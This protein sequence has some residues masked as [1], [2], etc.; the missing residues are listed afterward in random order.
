M[1]VPGQAGSAVIDVHVLLAIDSP[2][3][4]T[5]AKLQSLNSRVLV[6]RRFSVEVGPARSQL[7]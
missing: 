5:I 3:S 4:D 6:T 1:S 2:C 7:L